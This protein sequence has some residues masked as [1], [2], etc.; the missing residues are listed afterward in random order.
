MNKKVIILGKLPP[1]YMGPAIATDLL[2]KSELKNRFQLIHLDT[3]INKTLS[4]FGKWGFGKIFK[5]ISLYIKLWYL[6]WKHKP[7][8][9]LVP[10]SQ[11]TTG[12]IKDALFITVAGWFNTNIVIQLRGSSFKNWVSGSSHQVQ[13]YIKHVLGKTQGVIVL[14][15]NLKYLFTDYF[16]DNRIF[17]IPNGGNYTFPAINKHKQGVNMLYF[18]NLLAAKGIEDVF[19]AIALLTNHANSTLSTNC[20]FS[21][22]VVGAW[23]SKEVEKK[24]LALLK[25][26]NLPIRIHAPKSGQDKFRYLAEADVFVFPPREPEGH[27]WAIVEAMAAGLPIISTNQGAIIESVIDQK[28]GFIVPIKSPEKIAEKLKLLIENAELRHQMGIQ[29]KQLYLEHF[30]EEKMVEKYTTVFNS[31]IDHVT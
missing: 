27:P 30:T 11:T 19:E 31:F 17:V 3:R 24:C 21:L 1:P 13:R 5:S 15:H 7:N 22:D 2:L 12:F 23:D 16:N 6:L 8:V 4:S 26:G 9:V 20:S 29:S 28:N 25:K 10:I 14:G 18:S